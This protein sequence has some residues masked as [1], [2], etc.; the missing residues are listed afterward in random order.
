MRLSPVLNAPSVCLQGPSET[1][2]KDFERVLVSP[3][4]Q[5]G[6]GHPIMS[7]KLKGGHGH[8]GL[9][10][11]SLFFGIMCRIGFFFGFKDMWKTAPN[12]F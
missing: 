6:G 8:K 4:V 2:W 5:R 10:P 7:E 12:R 1:E 3:P 9:K 11:E